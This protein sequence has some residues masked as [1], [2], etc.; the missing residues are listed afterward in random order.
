MNYIL[1]Y[2]I[3]NTDYLNDQN[4]SKGQRAYGAGNEQDRNSYSRMSTGKSWNRPVGNEGSGSYYGRD[5]ASMRGNDYYGTQGYSNDYNRKNYSASTYGA[6]AGSGYGDTSPRSRG[7]AAAPAEFPDYSNRPTYG[8]FAGSRDYTNFMDHNYGRSA[9][10]SRYSSGYDNSIANYGNTGYGSTG[11]NNRDLDRE[12][13]VGA[14]NRYS[15]ANQGR[16]G[17]NDGRRR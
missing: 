3:M 2:Y 17:E 1:I 12:R 6:R 15:S 11:Y 9:E 14:R 16:Y 5:N 13:S 10:R 8:S 7:K 4:S